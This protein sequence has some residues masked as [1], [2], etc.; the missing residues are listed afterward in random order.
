M[1][2]IQGNDE[3]P[4]SHAEDRSQENDDEN[5][6]VGTIWFLALSDSLDSIKCEHDLCRRYAANVS[7]IDI[8]NSVIF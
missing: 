3:E 2:S 4:C 5:D 6:L 7:W 8:K 1:T